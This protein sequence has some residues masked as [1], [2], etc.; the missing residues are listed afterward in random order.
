V[1]ATTTSTTAPR[2]LPLLR[3]SRSRPSIGADSSRST[4]PV[5]GCFPRRD[6]RAR[7]KHRSSGMA[8]QKRAQL[9]P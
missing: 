3:H 8:D 9:R 7:I 5:V 2:I 6:T 4:P 1:P